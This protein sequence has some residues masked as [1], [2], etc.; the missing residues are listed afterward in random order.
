MS[1]LVRVAFFD[2]DGVLLDSLPQHLA[3][4]ET[5]AQ[6]FRLDIQ[7]PTVEEFRRRVSRGTKVSPMREFFLAVGFPSEVVDDAVAGYQREFM[8]RFPPP[9]F[10][11]VDEML[12]RL[13]HDGWLLGLVTSNTRE[14][15]EPALH[16]SLGLF[17]QRLRF[18]HEPDGPPRSK[19]D[20]LL[21]GAV[22]V[23]AAP[24]DCCFIGDQS[25]DQ[26]AADD[27]GVRFLGVTY[28]WGFVPGID[29]V[30]AADRVS[31]IPGILGQLWRGKH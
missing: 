20:C 5:Y 16:S 1:H 17:P 25:A 29:R 28:G 19:K 30:D 9:K 6:E 21:M 23:G 27:A 22:N 15:V 24:A 14:N 10:D 11:G 31:Q 3:I 7:I 12:Q 4:C 18:Y 2:V 13:A 8:S 26:R